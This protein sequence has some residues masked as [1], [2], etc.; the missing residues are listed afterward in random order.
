MSKLPLLSVRPNVH[1]FDGVCTVS[2]TGNDARR[3]ILGLR[4]IACTTASGPAE[5]GADPSDGGSPNGAADRERI[6][7]G[8]AGRGPVG[9]GPGGSWYRRTFV[10]ASREPVNWCDVRETV[11]IV[12]TLACVGDTRLWVRVG[13]A[14]SGGGVDGCANPGGGNWKV[15]CER[16][17]QSW[18]VLKL[19]GESTVLLFER[20]LFIRGPVS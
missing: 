2:M 17:F 14:E 8:G 12:D 5:L 18:L 15:D 13:G 9:I 7:G 19:G 20:C 10:E 11:E 3:V 16:I 6:T 4:G 1:G